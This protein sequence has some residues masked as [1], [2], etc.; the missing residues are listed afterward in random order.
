MVRSNPIK[1]GLTLATKK[2]IKDAWNLRQIGFEIRFYNQIWKEKK[3]KK[4]LK[5]NFL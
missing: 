5:M 1:E 2:T 4:I 3:A